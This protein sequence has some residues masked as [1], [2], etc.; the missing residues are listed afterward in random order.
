MFEFGDQNE[1]TARDKAWLVIISYLLTD[2]PITSTDIMNHADVS[3]DVARSALHAAE[4][5][6]LLQRHSPR[7]HTYNPTKEGAAAMTS[8]TTPNNEVVDPSLPVSKSTDNESQDTNPYRTVSPEFTHDEIRKRD[9]VYGVWYREVGDHFLF[10]N[11]GEFVVTER[12]DKLV[13]T[14]QSLSGRETVTFTIDWDDHEARFEFADGESGVVNSIRLVDYT[15]HPLKAR[16]QLQVY[17]DVLA[18]EEYGGFHA[19]ST[20]FINDVR[21]SYSK[22]VQEV[23][24]LKSDDPTVVTEVRFAHDLENHV[25]LRVHEKDESLRVILGYDDGIIGAGIHKVRSLGTHESLD[26]AYKGLAD[27]LRD[28]PN[29]FPELIPREEDVPQDVI[30]NYT[31]LPGVG[32]VT[33]KRLARHYPDGEIHGL[34]NENASLTRT[35]RFAIRN[36]HHEQM[37]EKY[38]REKMAERK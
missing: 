34:F 14:A 23:D 5:A 4:S 6:E 13:R 32:E 12:E 26:D 7:A 10:D 8:Q 30:D 15:T 11:R 25:V 38:Y 24:G 28:H 19:C 22:Y 37:A 21:S 35:A 36:E 2:E 3:R 27:I 16:I 9:V 33:A 18:D 29:G 1:L 17:R 20:W 31:E